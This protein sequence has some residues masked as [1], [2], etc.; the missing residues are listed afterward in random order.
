V[1]RCAWRI[2]LDALRVNTSS[3]ITPPEELPEWTAAVWWSGT[4][5]PHRAADPD[6]GRSTWR[7]AAEITEQTGSTGSQE[8]GEGVSGAA[9]TGADTAGE[10]EPAGHFRIYLGAA[11]GVGK[12]Y[13]M[14]SE[15]QRRRSR[16]ADVVAGFVETYGRPLTQALLN[17]LEIIPR[18]AAGYR[19]T[20]LEE[21][22]LDA[23]LR[24]R[25]RSYWSTSWPT[26]TFR[27]PVAMTNGGRTSWTSS[28]RESMSSL[29]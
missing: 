24:R 4:R 2:W 3:L 15:G 10:V 7:K 16:G 28:A 22:D 20:R 29:P 21:M 13:A 6:Q 23:V 1:S 12:T 18:R 19:G 5:L 17:S 26:P 11:P 9:E 14:L 25:P 8:T 27:D